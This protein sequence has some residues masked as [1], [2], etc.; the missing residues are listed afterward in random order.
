[1]ISNDLRLDWDTRRRFVEQSS[2]TNIHFRSSKN[3]PNIVQNV[4]WQSHW[5]WS[6][7]L[8]TDLLCITQAVA[9][10]VVSLLC[11]LF[12]GFPLW[13]YFIT[14]TVISMCVKRCQKRPTKKMI[15]SANE[16]WCHI[17]E[18]AK[19]ASRNNNCSQLVMSIVANASSACV[20]EL[21]S[22]G[23]SPVHPLP[24]PPPE[25]SR[26][27]KLAWRLHHYSE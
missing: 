12:I 19:E 7:R 10:K 25:R 20:L 11:A 22:H 27:E 6:G 18:D 21:H 4:E 2:T 5:C 23:E 3:A 9:I 15:T 13:W 1:M 17:T 24:P 14:V 26:H 16:N 8:N